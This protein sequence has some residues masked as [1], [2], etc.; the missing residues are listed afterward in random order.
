MWKTSGGLNRLTGTNMVKRWLVCFTSPKR[1]NRNSFGTA[2]VDGVFYE[3][4][5]SAVML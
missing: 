1:V 5:P 3:F 2:A 4:I